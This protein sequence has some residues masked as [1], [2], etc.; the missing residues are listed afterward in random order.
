M[1]IS[2]NRA[3]EA[4]GRIRRH[5]DRCLV[6]HYACQSLY[7]DREGLSPRISNIIVKDFTNDQTVSFAAHLTAEKLHISKTEIEDRFDDVERTLLEEFYAFVQSHSGN[8]WLH[9]NMINIQYGFETLAH[10]YYILTG[11]NAP[12]IEIDNRIN[13]AGIL[14][15]MYGEKYV[16]VPHMPKLMELNGG[17]RRDFVPG[18]EEVE[19]FKSK[20]YARLH[21]STVSKV[22]FFSDVVELILD[23]KLKTQQATIYVKIERATDSLVAK[24]IGLIAAIYAIISIGMAAFH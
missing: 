6:I 3:R 10:R 12:G 23:R 16:P 18:V 13:I 14:S 19:L 8:L 15:G 21:A 1:G 24:V 17:V 20:E 5:R 9:W 7:D 22:K 2:F 11:K 4:V